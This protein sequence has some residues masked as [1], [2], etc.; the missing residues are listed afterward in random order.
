VEHN[1]S[2][3]GWGMKC[4]QHYLDLITVCAK[5]CASM[6]HALITL[7]QHTVAETQSTYS[8]SSPN[9]SHEPDQLLP[10]ESSPQGLAARRSNL[11]VL[12]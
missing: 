4:P 11:P 5:S 3:A 6:L 8:S 7:L 12:V 10:E 2:H 1:S 9:Y